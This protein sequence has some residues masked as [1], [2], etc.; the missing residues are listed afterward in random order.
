MTTTP[1]PPRPLPPTPP[2]HRGAAVV[3]IGVFVAAVVVTVAQPLLRHDVDA[4]AFTRA[5]AARAS[6]VQ[7]GD[8]VLVHPPWRDDV[9]T[10]LRAAGAL[11]AAVTVTEAF[12]PRHGDPLPPLVV[13][14]DVG[15]PL[16]GNLAP[17]VPADAIA[18]DGVRVFRIGGAPSSSSSGGLE[19][20]RARVHVETADGAR[21]QCPWVPARRRHVCSGLPEWMTVGD[22]TLVVL[23]RRE[24]CTW[25]HPITGGIVVVDYGV[26][27]VPPTGLTLSAALTDA[28]ANNPAGAAVT[29]S[30]LL[31]DDERSVTV[32]HER[33]FH[34]VHVA[35]PAARGRLQVRVTTANDGQ[36]HTCYRLGPASLT[37]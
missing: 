36:R 32:Q 34:D 3:L 28:A 1:A 24:R 13:V 22:D 10:A 37:P 25:A 21:V 33:G 8:T 35:A 5:L 20:A 29:V 14:A 6:L 18:V 16:P 31:D 7:R 17:H 30:A 11:P 26:V 12:A 9:V 23:G 15:W 2:M 4:A 27:D 19:N